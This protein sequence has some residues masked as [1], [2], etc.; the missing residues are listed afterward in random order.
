[1][2]STPHQRAPPLIG[3]QSA[4]GSLSGFIVFFVIG[5]QDLHAIFRY[6]TGMLT[7]AL[8]TIFL[9]YFFGPRFHFCGRRLLR[10]GVLIPG[11]LLLISERSAAM[12]GNRFRWPAAS[13]R[14][15]PPRCFGR[16]RRAKYVF[17]L[18]GVVSRQD[19]PPHAA[20]VAQGSVGD[21]AAAS[22]M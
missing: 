19:N 17:R 22:S 13:P 20:R 21:P 15:W 14:H 12:D 2:K 3:L 9:T 5:T 6:T 18:Y 4:M 1:M 11:L 10:L 8:A 7:T 16:V